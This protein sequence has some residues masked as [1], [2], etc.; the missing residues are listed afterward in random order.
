MSL[1]GGAGGK[2]LGMIYDGFVAFSN[3]L[4]FP[5]CQ[6]I[7]LKGH[8]KGDCFDRV[9]EMFCVLGVARGCELCFCKSLS[10]FYSYTMPKLFI[11][12]VLTVW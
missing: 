7:C 8:F 11:L 5:H 1:R 6:V 9:S 3:S 2:R 10:S 12:K 4:G